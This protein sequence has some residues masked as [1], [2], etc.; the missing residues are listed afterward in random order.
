MEKAIFTYRFAIKTRAVFFERQILFRNFLR[1]HNEYRNEYQKLKEGLI[2]KNPVG[3]NEYISG[4]AEF[5][6]RVLKLA[7]FNNPN[8]IFKQN[9]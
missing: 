9:N 6:E 8:Y 3:D 4:K 2:K 1:K 7:G 5:V